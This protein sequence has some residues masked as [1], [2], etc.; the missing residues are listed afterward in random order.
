MTVKSVTKQAYKAIF[1]PWIKEW[2][3][4]CIYKTIK[5]F[6]NI[7]GNPSSDKIKKWV[8]DLKNN[9]SSIKI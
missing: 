6:F 1:G 7:E 2:A 9:K 3:Q 8:L 4:S 5:F